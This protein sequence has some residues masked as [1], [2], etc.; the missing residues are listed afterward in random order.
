MTR[1]IRN[2]LKEA[3]ARWPAEPHPG[4]ALDRYCREAIDDAGREAQRELMQ[5]L[6]QLPP[7]RVYALRFARWRRALAALPHV[8]MAE[9]AVTGRMRTGQGNPS[10]LESALT[11][12]QV[13][14]V[15][16]LPGSGLKGLARHYASQPGAAGTSDERAP[17]PVSYQSALFGDT[18]SASYLTW[19]DAWYVPGSADGRPFA[20][21]VV[22]VHHPKYYT[23]APGAR[24]PPWDLDDP[25]PIPMLS[26]RGSYLV[27]V[28]GPSDDWAQFALAVLLDALADWGAGGKTASGYGRLRTTAPVPSPGS[29]PA[30][31]RT[32]E[33]AEPAEHPLIRQVR[34]LPHARVKA[35][36][37]GIFQQARQLEGVERIAVMRAI[38]DRLE[39]VGALRDP[40]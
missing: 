9:C 24:R 2:N 4:L 27:A 16:Y 19:F 6:A 38:R 36:S 21:D 15:P 12:Q 5:R 30:A 14:G 32:P 7:P 39:A 28:Q 31:P 40:S 25:N 26:A 1:A 17:L 18:E 34:A 29:A 8:A 23:S 11:V 10:V 35:E 33:P 3:A 22:T 13:D 37:N 20:L